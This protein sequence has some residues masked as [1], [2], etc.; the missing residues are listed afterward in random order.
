MI[1]RAGRVV[2]VA[3]GSEVGRNLLARVVGVDAVDELITDSS[4]DQAEPAAI[5]AQNVKVTIADEPAC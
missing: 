3:D 2:V 1:G 5:R 4:A